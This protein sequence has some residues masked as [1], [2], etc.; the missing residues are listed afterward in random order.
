MFLLCCSVCLL[1]CLSSVC[2]DCAALFLF[3]DIEWV[4]VMDLLSLKTIFGKNE[5]F[6]GGF[7]SSSRVFDFCW[8]QRSCWLW[9]CCFPALK[10]TY[11]SLMP[12]WIGQALLPVR[13]AL[14]F[15][16][17]PASWIGGGK[18][19]QETTT[20]ESFLFHSKSHFFEEF[21]I[22]WMN[23][24]ECWLQ[25]CLTEFD[26]F[27]DEMVQFKRFNMTAFRIG[28]RFEVWVRFWRT[29]KRSFVF[30]A[31]FDQPI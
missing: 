25:F 6:L 7:A 20:L 5:C 4:L 10:T 1:F 29:F 12:A 27:C 8:K 21:W 30:R 17:A 28:G 14:P 23:L 18:I 15:H 24:G 16:F 13:F 11:F 3:V 9:F 26:C 19:V 22:K 2:K 31:L